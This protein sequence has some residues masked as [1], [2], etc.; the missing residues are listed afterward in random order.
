MRAAE[1]Q[2]GSVE[3][4]SAKPHLFAASRPPTS[5]FFRAFCEGRSRKCFVFLNLYLVLFLPT[6]AQHVNSLKT[7]AR[8]PALS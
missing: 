8:I 5:G 1:S 3:S 6:V 7:A 2:T 4:E